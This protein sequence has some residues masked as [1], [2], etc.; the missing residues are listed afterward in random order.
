[1]VSLG[2]GHVVLACHRL[3]VE[4]QVLLLREELCSRESLVTL[5]YAVNL[6]QADVQSL[7]KRGCVPLCG[8]GVGLER[9][10]EG[11]CGDWHEGWD[12]EG[13]EGLEGGDGVGV[14]AEEVKVE[15]EDVDPLLAAY[16]LAGPPTTAKMHK[17]HTPRKMLIT[18]TH[19]GA[20]LVTLLLVATFL[21]VL[22]GTLLDTMAFQFEGAVGLLL[23]IHH[24]DQVAYSF[25]TVGTSIPTHR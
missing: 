18:V 9:G 23:R 11:G 6:T 22:F 21:F 13:R 5:V 16:S 8:A 1:M 17:M 19:L 25:T 20:V 10:R 15:A 7:Q 3:V 2:I 24:S 14:G 12:W 4:P